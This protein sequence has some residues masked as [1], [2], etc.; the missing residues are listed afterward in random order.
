M[1][2]ALFQEE[3]RWHAGVTDPTPLAVV[4]EQ[5]L[6]GSTSVFEPTKRREVAGSNRTAA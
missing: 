6:A 2:L 1:C 5:S 3:Y 4:I